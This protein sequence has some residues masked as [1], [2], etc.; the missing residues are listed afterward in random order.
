M[1][2]S[3]VAT[4]SMPSSQ[5]SRRRPRRRLIHWIPVALL[6]HAEALL[7]LG[8]ATFFWVPRNADM[9]AMG[10]RG[11]PDSIDI[12]TV[13]DE[14]SRKILA[15]LEKQDEEAKEE[16]VKKEREAPDAPGQVIDLP[17]PK[18]EKH[19]DKARFAAEH[20]SSVTKETKKYGKFDDKAR[21]AS[22]GSADEPRPANP[23]SPP[24]PKTAPRPPGAMA[25]N[26]PGPRG[27]PGRPGPPGEAVS[28]ESGRPGELV[29]APTDENGELS[30]P[31]QGAPSRPRGGAM[32]GGVPSPSTSGAPPALLPSDQQLARAIGSGTQDYLKDIDEGDETALNAKKWKFASFFNRVK[33]QV[34]DHWRPAEE[35]R[36]RDPTGSIYGQKD[37]YTL[38]RVQLKP[39]GSLANVALENPSGIEFL[40]D[41]AI[42]AFKQAQP[43][44]NPPKQLVDGDSGMINFRF[45]FFFELSGSP[46][47][48]IFRYNSM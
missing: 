48:K 26:R 29:A 23:P 25:M 8:L 4:G 41:E 9:L 18:E 28:Q 34:R 19:P 46:R 35:Y 27:R 22:A 38:L 36:R 10:G 40:D 13:D 11:E 24:A 5:Q 1:A 45:G 3:S 6:I 20:D 12:S 47:F 39:D 31:G 2:G 30:P 44:P 33:Q 43:F 37:R 15:E 21:Q 7:V 17:T 42:E 14:T 32:G 16:E